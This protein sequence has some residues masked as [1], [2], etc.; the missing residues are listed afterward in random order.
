MHDFYRDLQDGEFITA[1]GFDIVVHRRAIGPLHLPTGKLVA[2]DPFEHPETEPFALD[3]PRGE[4][5]A[6]L[7]WAQ[8][9]DEVRVAYAVLELSP[10]PARRWSLATVPSEEHLEINADASFGYSVVSTFGSFMDVATASRLIEYKEIAMYED[11]DELDRLLH[12]QLQKRRR[13]HE[14]TWANLSHDILGA[15]NLI[16]VP[17]GYGRGTY[18]TY[19]GRTHGGEV[20]RI[21]TDFEVLDMTFPSFGM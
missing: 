11:E 14:P 3:L 9:R 7:V 10:E 21:V 4:H 5:T 2:C 1:L 6:R 20:T 15:G 17:A 18:R 19:I 8:L 13:K 12:A 16:V